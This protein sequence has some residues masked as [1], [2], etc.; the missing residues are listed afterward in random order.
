M[1]TVDRRTGLPVI[2]KAELQ[3]IFVHNGVPHDIPLGWDV[4][5]TGN[6]RK[7]DRAFA[8]QFLTEE[9]TYHIAGDAVKNRICII[10]KMTKKEVEQSIKEIIKKEKESVRMAILKIKDYRRIGIVSHESSPCNSSFPPFKCFFHR[11]FCL[12]Y[13]LVNVNSSHYFS[14][15]SAIGAAS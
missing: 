1:L 4:I 15:S 9:E 12:L 8:G 5:K 10:R 6:I 11:F 3:K 14:V 13:Y 2:T 7:G